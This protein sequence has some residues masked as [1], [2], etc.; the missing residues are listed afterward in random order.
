M[1]IKVKPRTQSRGY[2]LPKGM[3]DTEARLLDKRIGNKVVATPG[4]KLP[5]N[6]RERAALERWE[7][8][9]DGKKIG[10]I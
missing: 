4:R 8:K 2:S 7:R 1:A 10:T 5:R 9:R 3:T 6:P